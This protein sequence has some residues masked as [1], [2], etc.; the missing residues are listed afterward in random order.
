MTLNKRG[1]GGVVALVATTHT[2]VK[3]RVCVGERER[4]SPSLPSMVILLR[5]KMM[6][7]I[8]IVATKMFTINALTSLCISGIHLHVQQEMYMY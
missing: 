8:I 1:G 6:V 2:E 5:A 3:Q 7:T 4:E